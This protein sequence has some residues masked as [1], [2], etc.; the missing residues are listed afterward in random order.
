[1]MIRS[2][3]LRSN[4]FSSG[5]ESYKVVPRMRVIA[6]QN[7]FITAAA[8]LAYCASCPLPEGLFFS[9][10]ISWAKVLEED[11]SLA[12]EIC[13]FCDIVCDQTMKQLVAYTNKF[14]CFACQSSPRTMSFENIPFSSPKE[15]L[16]AF[17]LVHSFSHQSA[18][19]PGFTHKFQT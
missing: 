12:E 14:S 9:A 7:A 4:L 5:R 18:S 10:G 17:H 11:F 15:Y 19:D 13:V 6:V 2:H 8:A 3:A 1:M 16:F